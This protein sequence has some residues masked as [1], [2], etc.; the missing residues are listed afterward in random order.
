MVHNG[1]KDIFTSVVDLTPANVLD[2]INRTLVYHFENKED[3]DYLYDYRRGEQPILQRTKERNEDICC[4]KVVENHAEE[5]VAFKDGYFLQE[6]LCYVARNDESGDKVLQLNEYLYR[7]GKHQADNE[8][9]DWFHTV[10]RAHLFVEPVNDKE[11][12]FLAYALDPRTAEVV[13]SLAP[14]NRPAYGMHIVSQE[15]ELFVDVYTREKFFRLYG[16]I[17]PQHPTDDP[18]KRVYVTEIKEMSENRLAPYIPII[19]YKYNRTNMSAF[20]SVLSL[21]DLIN[22]IRSNSMD[23]IEQL[24]QSLLVAINVDFEDD[25]DASYVRERGM[26]CIPSTGD[27]KADIKLLSE[28][29]NQADTEVLVQSTLTEMHKIVGMPFVNAGGTSGNVGSAIYVNGWTTAE[30]YAKNTEDEFKKSNRYFDEIMIKILKD[31]L[32]FDISIS[33]FELSFSRNELANIQAKAQSA[34]TMIGF[35]LHPILALEWSG[36]TNDPVGAYEQSKEFFEAKQ[37]YQGDVTQ[38]G[39]ETTN[40][41]GVDDTTYGKIENTV[42]KELGI[43]E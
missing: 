6:N 38:Y 14:G 12:P 29:L 33:D 5:I 34:G 20:E 42:L 21:C 13:Y 2:E 32:K 17:N 18:N 15:E 41:Y 7:S 3:E 27:N 1:R 10:G 40:A 23:G 9:V 26:L 4:N 30:A 43:R 37:Q 25:V 19:E 35:G 24:I 28:D 39:T 16:T 11:C 36:L 8:L 22:N 31:I